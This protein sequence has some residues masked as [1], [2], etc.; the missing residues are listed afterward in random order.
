[1]FI[2]FFVYV[3]DVLNGVDTEYVKNKSRHEHIEDVENFMANSWLVAFLHAYTFR[4]FLK[5]LIASSD[6]LYCIL[7]LTAFDI[8]KLLFGDFLGLN[9]LNGFLKKVLNLLLVS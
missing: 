3:E 4:G 6:R 2:W 5:L 1:M 7:A 9:F 8:W